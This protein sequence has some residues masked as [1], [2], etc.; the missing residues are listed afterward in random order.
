[1][2]PSEAAHVTAGHLDL[3][4]CAGDL[5]ETRLREGTE[6]PAPWVLLAIPLSV[7]KS[8]SHAAPCLSS[9]SKLLQHA[10]IPLTPWMSGYNRDIS[11][12]ASVRFLAFSPFAV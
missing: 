3:H 10:S 1:V 9:S 8:I 7:L 4:N 12:V 5:K 11:A 2:G 6:H